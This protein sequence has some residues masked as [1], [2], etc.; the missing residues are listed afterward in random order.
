MWSR[1]AYFLSASASLT[2]SNSAGNDHGTSEHD[3]VHRHESLET[4]EA[5]AGRKAGLLIDAIRMKFFK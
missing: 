1:H 4:I 3:H 2:L 5:T